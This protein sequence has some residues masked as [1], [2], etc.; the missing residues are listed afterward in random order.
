MRIK[1]ACEMVQKNSATVSSISVSSTTPV[2]SRYLVN[3]PWVKVWHDYG[4]FQR[5]EFHK[6]NLKV[7][8]YATFSA[9]FW[10]KREKTLCIS[11]IKATYTVN[12]LYWSIN[13]ID[14][15]YCI[16][17]VGQALLKSPE[18]SLWTREARCLQD[19]FIQW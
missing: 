16:F 13:Y 10:E 5:F 8:I 19:H 4:S 18:I 11:R 2:L 12:L 3:S 6:Q 9:I 7:T 15:I 17:S 1:E 14:N